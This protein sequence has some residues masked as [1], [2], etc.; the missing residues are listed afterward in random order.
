MRCVLE[1]MIVVSKTIPA[2]LINELNEKLADIDKLS[3]V[4]K[5]FMRFF[6]VEILFIRRI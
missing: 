1:V 4:I 5:K 2:V 3:G 6:D